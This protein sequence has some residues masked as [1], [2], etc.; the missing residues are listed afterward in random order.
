MQ[1][2]LCSALIL[3]TGLAV[4]SFA[5]DA[6]SQTTV[7]HSPIGVTSPAS[8][9]EM[10]NSYCASCHGQDAKGNGPV[11]SDLKNPPADLTQLSAKNGGKFPEM[12]VASVIE[13]KASLSSHGTQDMPVWGPLFSQ[14]SQGQHAVVHQRVT[15]LT[16]YIES[17]QAK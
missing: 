11:A 16:K 3:C 1:K 8:G 15:N 5:Q 13:G 6:S 7:K 17:L 12:H 14:I 4:W 2:V 10:F 9:K